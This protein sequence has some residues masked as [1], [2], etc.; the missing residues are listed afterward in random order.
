MNFSKPV[1][2]VSKCLGFEKCRWN[3]NSIENKF[4]KKLKPYVNFITVCPECEINLPT[5]RKPLKLVKDKEKGIILI[6]H[7]TLKNLTKKMKNFSYEFSK[8]LKNINPD[9]AILKS[10]SPSCGVSDAKIYPSIKGSCA[11]KRIQM[12]ALGIVKETKGENKK[13]NERLFSL[14]K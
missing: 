9:G 11:N 14:V 3:R 1:I 4:I 12:K 10:K 6:Q 13:L 2:L 8:N 5:P 7:E